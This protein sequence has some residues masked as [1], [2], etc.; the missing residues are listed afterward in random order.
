MQAK[1]T[2]RRTYS[3]PKLTIYG[4]LAKYTAS[5]TGG[6]TESMTTGQPTKVMV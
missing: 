3:A 4:G 6:D 5:G 2:E 1:S